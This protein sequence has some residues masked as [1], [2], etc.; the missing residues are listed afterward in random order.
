MSIISHSIA[1]KIMPFYSAQLFRVQFSVHFMCVCTALYIL[2]ASHILKV[3][4]LSMCNC[5][6][7]IIEIHSVSV[8]FENYLSKRGQK[9][10]YA[11]VVTG[12]S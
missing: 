1:E 4:A 3:D 12:I 10:I 8:I 6:M 2:I 7:M 9:F 11:Y 5:M